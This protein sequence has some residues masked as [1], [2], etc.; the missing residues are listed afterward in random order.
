M[1]SS[2]KPN[3]AVKQRYVT[4][5]VTDLGTLTVLTLGAG[6]SQQDSAPATLGRK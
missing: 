5:A 4:P 1:T 2:T 6:G 3:A